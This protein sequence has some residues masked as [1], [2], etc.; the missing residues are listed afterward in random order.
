MSNNDI[1]GLVFL[2]L[3]LLFMVSLFMSLFKVIGMKKSPD[4]F[5]GMAVLKIFIIPILSF[6]A[7]MYFVLVIL[8]DLQ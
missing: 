3:G 6:V 4:N 2:I 1:V 7:L 8:P 5:K